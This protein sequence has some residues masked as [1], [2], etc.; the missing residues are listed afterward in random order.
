MHAR[1]NPPSNFPAFATQA[2]CCALCMQLSL[3]CST[4]I[5]CLPDIEYCVRSPSVLRPQHVHLMPN[6]NALCVFPFL[7]TCSQFSAH[8][9][10]IACLMSN[11]LV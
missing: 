6:L 7:R 10:S 3:V 9:T 11:A 8:S 1:N 4:A 2:L 5:L